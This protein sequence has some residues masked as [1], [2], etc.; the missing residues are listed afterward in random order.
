MTLVQFFAFTPLIF[1][2]H[3]LVSPASPPPQGGILHLWPPWSPRWEL[4]PT[5]PGQVCIV[6]EFQL[7]TA[8]GGTWT[9]ASTQVL[10]RTTSDGKELDAHLCKGPWRAP[11]HC[12]G[13]LMCSSLPSAKDTTTR[14]ELQLD[15]DSFCALSCY[16]R[17]GACFSE[18]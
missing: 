3:H 1:W 10:G 8:A 13:I 4:F 15:K 12:P 11:S 6:T 5:L 17:V 2:N 18:E 7:S 9:H 14:W 16:S